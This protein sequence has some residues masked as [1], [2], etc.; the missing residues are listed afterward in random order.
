MVIGF[1]LENI[2]VLLLKFHLICVIWIIYLDLSLI[3]LPKIFLIVHIHFLSELF[4]QS[5]N[6][7]I[8][9]LFLSLGL[10]SLSLQ[11]LELLVE[12]GTLISNL[13][14][15]FMDLLCE[16]LE[17]TFFPLLLEKLLWNSCVKSFR[18]DSLAGDSRCHLFKL[19]ACYLG[20]LNLWSL[21]R[22]YKFLVLFLI[23]HASHLSLSLFL[24]FSFCNLF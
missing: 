3:Y 14:S 9:L 19:I 13:L 18:M 20:S 6:L 24:L 16:F 21:W 10:I 12:L 8:C 7:I 2:H 5:V 11:F 4:F 23:L 22:S 15:H 1:W 17:L